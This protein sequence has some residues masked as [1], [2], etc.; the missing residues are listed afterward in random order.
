[1]PKLRSSLSPTASSL[2]T[3]P[4]SETVNI[5]EVTPSTADWMEHIYLD[6]CRACQMRKYLLKPKTPVNY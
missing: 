6:R 5:T 1:V 3:F 2:P 4:R